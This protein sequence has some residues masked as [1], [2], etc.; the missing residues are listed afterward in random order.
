MHEPPERFLVGCFVLLRRRRRRRRRPRRASSN[1]SARLTSCTVSSYAEKLGPDPLIFNSS[2]KSLKF[3]IAAQVL[4]YPGKQSSKRFPVSRRAYNVS[5]VLTHT[6]STTTR[7]RNNYRIAERSVL[8]CSTTRI[9]WLRRRVTP[10][11]ASQ[12]IRKP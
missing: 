3:L 8:H 9:T 10:R 5:I 1:S 4:S 7:S 2:D 12:F 6:D 11:A